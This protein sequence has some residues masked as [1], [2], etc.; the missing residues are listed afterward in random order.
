MLQ[1]RSDSYFAKDSSNFEMM[2]VYR[3]VEDCVQH[4]LVAEKLCIQYF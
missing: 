3:V 2:R 4:M 1:Y